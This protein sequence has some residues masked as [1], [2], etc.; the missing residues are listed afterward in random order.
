M[1]NIDLTSVERNSY[2]SMFDDGLV[3]L[4]AGISLLF[5]G[6]T[7]LTEY[8]AFGGLMPVLLIPFWPAV[9]KKLVEPRSGYVR[10][11]E[12]RRRR[13]RQ[14]M[15]GSILLGVLALLLAVTAYFVLTSDGD[16]GREIF[17]SIGPGLPAFLLTLMAAMAA[18]WFD[19]PRF[20]G[21]AGV[22]LVAGLLGIWLDLEPAWSL[23]GSALIVTAT[24]TALLVRFVRNT[25][26]VEGR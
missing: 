21:Y 24:G 12:P 9:R 1:T 25:P 5:L 8:A 18:W 16:R 13:I 11:A 20:F 23:L 17:D 15:A 4:F 19:L 6:V 14:G 10:L 26:I 3:D 2:R 22:L 7:W